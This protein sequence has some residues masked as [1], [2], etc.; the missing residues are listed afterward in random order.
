MSRVQHVQIA[1]RESFWEWLILQHDFKRA[2]TISGYYSI[3][4]ELL[5]PQYARWRDGRTS[6]IASSPANNITK[7]RPPLSVIER[8]SQTPKILNN[9]ELYLVR[10][11]EGNLVV[12]DMR[13]FLPPFLSLNR[14]DFSGAVDLPIRL[15]KGYQRFAW[16]F[17]TQWNE[18][19]F[20]RAL[21]Y[22]GAFS[23]LLHAIS[24]HRT[25]KYVTGPSGPI[26]SRFYFWM[27]RNGVNSENSG[28]VEP[29]KFE[30][31][32]DLDEC[33]YPLGTDMIIPIEAK[34]QLFPDLAWHKLAFPC[35]RLFGPTHFQGA[36][37]E[38]SAAVAAAL[39][40]DNGKIRILPSFCWYSSATKQAMIHVFPQLQ[41]Y[42]GKTRAFSVEGKVQGVIL[43]EKRQMV[44]E[45]TFRI[46]MSWI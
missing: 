24:K 31:V 9:S 11:G 22:C 16:Q 41:L 17:R 30:G 36:V 8:L 13:Q 18:T 15:P 2:I 43:N 44:P 6:A 4:K 1:Q 33:L 26:M 38:Q 10:T 5:I 40:R 25:N 32:V 42:S 27:R 46:D 37:R 34:L 28:R 19:S 7:N 39:R 21:H 12:F 23:S 45:Q 3:N 35:N 29:F 14:M 20:I